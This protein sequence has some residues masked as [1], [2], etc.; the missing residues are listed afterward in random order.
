MISISNAA[1]LFSQI[2]LNKSTQNI[3]SLNQQLSTGLRINSSKDDAAGLAISTKM[4]TRIQGLVTAQRNVVD[5]TSFLQVGESATSTM[6]DILQ[7]MSELTGL[8]SNG[9]LSTTDRAKYNSE[10]TSL[11]AE[12]DDIAN[13]A[14]FNGL[15][16][17]GANAG[18]ISFQVGPDS[19][20]TMTVTTASLLTVNDALVSVDTVANAAL[21]SAAIDT[22][23]E[24]IATERANYGANLSRLDFKTDNLANMEI[25]QT[26]ARDNIMNADYAKVTS[27]LVGEQIKQQA[28]IAALGQANASQQ[29][30]LSLLG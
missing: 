19:G 16:M 7:R 23:L 1:S 4:N 18:A 6:T 11:T 22:A 14:E 20:D 30:I 3:E 10:Y 24:T 15:N 13:A 2:S 29:L 28:S 12:L 5:A 9:T 26:K 17:T 27:Q 21:A 8:A 25:S